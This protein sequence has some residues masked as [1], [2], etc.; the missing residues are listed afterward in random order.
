VAR[1]AAVVGL[2]WTVGDVDHVGDAVLALGGLAAGLAQRPA[3]PQVA[4]QLALERAARLHVQRRI[5]G[6]RGHPHLRLVGEPAAQPPGDLL[7]RE[8]SPQIVLHDF[9]QPRVHGQLGGLRAAG[10]LERSGVRRRR[11]VVAVTVGVALEL[12]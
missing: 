1:D 5:D 4:R 11:A 8:A 2:W 9:P 3:R 12:T 6:L 7:G 10:T